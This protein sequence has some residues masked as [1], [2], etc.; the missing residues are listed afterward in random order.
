MVARKPRIVIVGAGMAGLTAANRLVQ[1][2][3][4]RLDLIV[5]EASNRIGGRIY[6]SEFGGSRVEL[7]ATWI[8][9]IGGSPLHKIS[10]R[11]G[12]LESD[13][14]WERM[15]DLPEEFIVKAEGG[16]TVDPTVVESV[17]RLYRT[18]MSVAQGKSKGADTLEF[19]I[20]C[21]A[22]A[23]APR[24]PQG[25]LSIGSFL[26]HGLETFCEAEKA[27][28]ASKNGMSKPLGACNGNNSA[29]FGSQRLPCCWTQ[30]LLKEG[31]FSIHENTERTYTSAGSLLDL[32]FDAEKEYREFPGEQITI[33]KGYS[34]VLKA[35]ASV[36]PPGMI[37][38][39]KKVEKIVWTDTVGVE[40]P[41][42]APVHLHLEDGSVVDADHVVITVS[43]GVLKAG[44]GT[45][46]GKGSLFSPALPE[47]KLNA[48]SKLGFGV[49]D[50]LFVHM[51]P[52][53][54]DTVYPYLQLAFNAQAH[55][56]DKN[57]VP[58]WMRRT[59]SVYPIYDK[60]HVLLL[61]F[62]GEEARKVECLTDEEIIKGFSDTLSCFGLRNA[63]T[64]N[65][66]LKGEGLMARK[67]GDCKVN[68]SVR[69]ILRSKWCFDPFFR[70]SYSYVAVGSSGQDIDR[71]AE[72]LP[73]RTTQC[74]STIVPPLQLLFAGEA[75]HRTHYS[76]THGAYFSGL[77]EANR[78]LQHYGWG[79]LDHFYD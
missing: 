5:I 25:R 40:M 20:A 65:G 18:L 72:P 45:S 41:C 64:Q 73:K 43:L 69:K 36:L 8:H 67:S 57:K 74:H 54:A 56:Q 22:V 26:R 2:A 58:S 32:D 17:S 53:E 42:E 23:E 24:N 51:E 4:N 16:Q 63:S 66:H 10:E 6:T 49:V 62:A 33:A 55:E 75:T 71:L 52:D 77:R 1:A 9:G 44:I 60:S 11:I 50:K 79:S 28:E 78:L 12:S 37:Q 35:L 70:G 68:G 21:K 29:V 34:S 19:Q 7:G 76:T 15:D 46:Q 30:K 14:P 48:I 59:A 3:H 38:F 47:S 13:K 31:L 39:G 27:L 61:W